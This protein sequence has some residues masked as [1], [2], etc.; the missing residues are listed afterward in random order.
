M[1]LRI[2][3]PARANRSQRQAGNSVEANTME[4]IETRPT[5]NPDR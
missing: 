4:T 1:E 3:T 2:H 5:I